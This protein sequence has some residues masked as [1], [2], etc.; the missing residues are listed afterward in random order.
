MVEN[1]QIHISIPKKALDK[2]S[3]NYGDELLAQI[4][5]D[6]I[7]IQP[8]PEKANSQTQSLR[9]FM[10]PA[11]LAGVVALINF[12]IQK[13]RYVKLSGGNSI[14]QI[15][16]YLAVVFGFVV[17]L[18]ALLLLGGKQL[19]MASLWSK[20]RSV[21]TLSI[22]FTILNFSITSFCFYFID[23]AFHGVMLDRYTSSAL[24]A[25]FVG[26]S[27]YLMMN[28]ALSINFSTIT[29]TLILTLVGGIFLSM[30]TNKQQN[31]WQI[32]FSYLGSNLSNN[33]WQFNFTLIFS[34]LIMLTLIDYI[35]SL[36]SLIP[37]FIT[38]QTR[39][40]RILLTGS[41]IAFGLVGVF[42]NNRAI[43]WLHQLHWWTSN[44]LVAF[45]LLIIIGI[46]WLLPGITKEFLLT[47]YGFAG[48]L[49]LSEILF[50]WVHYLSLTAFE[51]ISFG[52]A[53]GWLILLMQNLNN[54]YLE[55]AEIFT[56]EIK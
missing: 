29:T 36:L 2:L 53:F 14:S 3:L 51:I 33:W 6:R 41:S 13:T 18:A 54:L 20:I 40:L 56:I 5:R 19:V 23:L 31:W 12:F 15:T 30:I 10:L 25:G 43:D 24:I 21:L 46:R 9:W 50:Q 34:A 4:D 22:A 44:L 45:I 28:A 52:L 7:I 16:I 48:L 38:I 1:Q 8:K 42:Q 26:I 37:K 27:C 17:F 39:I 35:F 49:A 47:A 11:L 32:N 55:N